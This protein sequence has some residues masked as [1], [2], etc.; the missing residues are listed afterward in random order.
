MDSHDKKQESM[1]DH[2]L[3]EKESYKNDTY[4]AKLCH[5]QRKI[6][7]ATCSSDALLRFLGGAVKFS[8]SLA[9]ADSVSE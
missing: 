3:E 4:H 7:V 8:P 1:L 6:E 2:S 9:T 5:V